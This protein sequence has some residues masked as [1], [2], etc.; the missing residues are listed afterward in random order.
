M[1][2][3]SY[4]PA[5]CC[6]IFSTLQQSDMSHETFLTHAIDL[7]LTHSA[8]GRNG[9]FGA[10]VVRD[11]QIVG[12]GWNQVVSSHDPT[13]HAEVMAIRDAGKQL[14]THQLKDC[15]LYTSCEPCAMCLAAIYWARIPTV[16][17]ACTMEDAGAAEFDDGVIYDELTQPWAKRRVAGVNLLR[18]QGQAVF[19]AW[20]KNPGRVQY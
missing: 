10:V 6:R 9:P 2:D 11:K 4:R 7:A 17:Y 3:D 15:T 19:K 16:Y 14:G 12:Q 1:H 5:T 8:D 13:A 18:D 20:H